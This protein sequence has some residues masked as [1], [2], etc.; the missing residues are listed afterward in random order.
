VPHEE[1]K[2]GVGSGE[3]PPVHSLWS[4]GRAEIVLVL[5]TVARLGAVHE[6][7]GERRVGGRRLAPQ[8]RPARLPPAN[9]LVL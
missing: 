8:R 5:A 1:A 9:V 7:R 4:V 2:D 3:E 6:Q